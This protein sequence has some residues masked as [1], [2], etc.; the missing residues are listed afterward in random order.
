MQQILSPNSNDD[1]VWIHQN[2]WFHL[3]NFD[4]E[5]TSD[6]QLNNP[7]NGVYAFV[8][9]GSFELNG[10]ILQRRDGM[11]LSG[12]ELISIK[13]LADKSSLLLMEVTMAVN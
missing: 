10:E 8:L 1:G 3:G 11:G 4:K 13:S 2:A 5:V 12:P 9:E 7:A 6:Y